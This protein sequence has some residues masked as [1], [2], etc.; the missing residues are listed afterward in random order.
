MLIC[1]NTDVTLLT[2][3]YL[4]QKSITLNIYILPSSIIAAVRVTDGNDS[5]MPLIARFMRPPRGPSGAD[6]TQVGPMNFAIWGVSKL[7]LTN[8]VV[9]VVGTGFTLS[10]CPSICRRHVFWNVT[11]VCCG[12]SISNFERRRLQNGRLATI[13]NFCFVSGLYF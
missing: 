6:R 11:T 4:P 12:I 13:L 2:S 8:L 5:Y 1:K 3:I 9:L 7:S 10:V